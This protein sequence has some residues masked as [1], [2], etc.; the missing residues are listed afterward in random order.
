MPLSY[1]APKNITDIYL[2]FTQQLVNDREE[3]TYKERDDVSVVAFENKK[4]ENEDEGDVI[5]SVR[6]FI[7]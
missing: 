3:E 5:A 4:T 6:N 1:S 7:E 2:K